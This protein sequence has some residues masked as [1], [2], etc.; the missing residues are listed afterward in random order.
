MRVIKA[1]PDFAVFPGAEVYLV[2]ALTAGAA[3]CISATANINATGIASLIARW[4][5]SDAED[6]QQAVNVV[7]QAA[8]VRGLIPSL[9]AV[10]AA[11]Y[12]DR[13]WLN[14]RPPLTP[15]SEAGRTELLSDPSI[16][17]LIETRHA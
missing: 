2:R 11:R 3:G 5:E 6:R 10:I 1:F 7:R 8:E 16:A 14:V 17:G 9:K 12:G 4:R 13:M 15:I